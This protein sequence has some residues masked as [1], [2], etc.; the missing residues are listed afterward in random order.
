VR[1][2]I[3]AL[4]PDT[5]DGAI[6]DPFADILNKPVVEKYMGMLEDRE[7][8]VINLRYGLN[9]RDI[10]TLQE[11]GGK[12]RRTT[13]RIQ[14]IEREALSKLRPKKPAVRLC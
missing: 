10:M 6:E 9:G 5:G 2:L 11:I 8:K 7:R 1:A 3:Q 14:Q 13:Q 4:L 12:F